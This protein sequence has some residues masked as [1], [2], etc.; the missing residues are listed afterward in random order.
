[1]FRVRYEHGSMAASLNFG[2][3]RNS[4]L[5][6]YRRETYFTGVNTHGKS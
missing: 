2:G 6:I 1:M 3:G 4:C 5:N